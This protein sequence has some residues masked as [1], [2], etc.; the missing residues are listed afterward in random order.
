MTLSTSTMLRHGACVNMHILFGGTDA[1]HLAQKLLRFEMRRF[2]SRCEAVRWKITTRLL[3][4]QEVLILAAMNNATT[5]IAAEERRQGASQN[6]T[7]RS[8]HAIQK[9][10][11]A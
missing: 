11:K 7:K 9:L 8:I 10:H 5:V 3:T 1:L 6:N 4:L 2:E